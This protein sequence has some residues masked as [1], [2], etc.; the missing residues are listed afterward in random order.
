MTE[1]PCCFKNLQEKGVVTLECNHKMCIKCF[2]GWARKANTCPCC[3]AAFADPPSEVPQPRP[4]QRQQAT[5]S[6]T[7]ARDITESIVATHFRELNDYVAIKQH[8]MVGIG[9]SRQQEKIKE[10]V[11]WNIRVMAARVKLYYEAPVV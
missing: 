3:R 5:Q 2:T 10:I 7:L 6:R 8:E 4:Q 1:C 11:D 9:S